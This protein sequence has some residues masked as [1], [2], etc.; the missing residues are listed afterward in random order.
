M[1]KYSKLKVIEDLCK[2]R[3]DFQT[4]LDIVDNRIDYLENDETEPRIKDAIHNL[5]NKFKSRHSLVEH[6][7]GKFEILNKYCNIFKW[8]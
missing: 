4:N 8:C 3:N 1:T 5:N 2:Q 6:F 7:C